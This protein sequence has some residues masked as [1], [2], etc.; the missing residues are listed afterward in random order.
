[1][2][3]KHKRHI[4]D[5][6]SQLDSMHKSD[7]RKYMQLVNS[8]KEGNFDKIK[9]SDTSSIS[10]DNWFSHFSSLLGKPINPNKVDLEMEAFLKNNIDTIV[11]E[12][13]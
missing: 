7:P 10:P 9:P 12:M 1:M 2:K 3:S 11:T 13:D 5:L 8:L 4:D 6:F